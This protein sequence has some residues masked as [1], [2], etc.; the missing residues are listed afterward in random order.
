MLNYIINLLNQETTHTTMQQNMVL[1]DSGQ[2]VSVLLSETR[3]SADGESINILEGEYAQSIFVDDRS[4]ISKKQSMLVIG[5]NPGGMNRLKADSETVDDYNKQ[6]SKTASMVTTES[7]NGPIIGISVCDSV[8]VDGSTSNFSKSPDKPT[9]I[10]NIDGGSKIGDKLPGFGSVVAPVQAIPTNSNNIHG[11]S[12]IGNKLTGFGSCLAPVQV[13]P[14]N[15]SNIDGGSKIGDKLPGFGSSLYPAQVQ[16]GNNTNIYSGSDIDVN[17]SPIEGSNVA[18]VQAKPTDNNNIGPGSKVGDKLL[19]FRS[20]VDPV[21]KINPNSKPD[22]TNL[23]N[24]GKST[25]PLNSIK[26]SQ[27]P[28]KTLNTEPNFSIVDKSLH[29]IDEDS[30]E[31][32]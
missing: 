32:R 6:K 18:P 14:T 13:Q 17:R 19:G 31:M 26:T 23:S 7:C 11:G 8:L 5:N 28:E 30:N 15:S 24:E 2:I 4:V 10:N 27:K 22:Q 21:Q 25:D 20:F 3:D 16:P 29:S 1:D 12:K 9:N